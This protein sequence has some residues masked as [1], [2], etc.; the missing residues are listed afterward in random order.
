MTSLA[1]AA[2][3]PQ[4][5]DVADATQLRGQAQAA[6]VA[7]D[8]AGSRRHH[9]QVV[10]HPQASE[11]QRSDSLRQLALQAWRYGRDADA[12]L[13][14]LAHALRIARDAEVSDS[15]RLTR[16]GIA[17]EAGHALQARSDALEVL[18]QARSVASR[19]EAK[20]IFARQALARSR[21]SHAGGPRDPAVAADL[22]QSR[23]FLDEVLEAQPGRTEAAEVQ[24]A[25]GVELGD[26][27]M[28]LRG[29]MG[30]LLFRD[31]AAV[32]PLMQPAHA[33]LRRL[34][35]VWRG[36]PLPRDARAAL[37]SAL[38][39]A[40]F[41]DVAARVAA[42]VSRP[43]NDLRALIA[44]DQFLRDV[45]AVNDSH[46]PR[47]AHGWREHRQAYDAA[48]VQAGS[49]LLRT[50]GVTAAEAKHDVEAQKT[51]LLE[52]LRS[53][54]G[55]EG[56][57]GVTMGF[58]GLLA[59]HVV[60]DERRTIVQHG[61]AGDFRHV[62]IDRLISRDFTSWYGT[63][64]VGGWGTA[65][66]MFQVRA[67]YLPGPLAQLAWVTD[68]QRRSALLERI[69]ALER[70][71]LV[72]C[73]ADP[74]ADPQS[75]PLRLKLQASDRLYRQLTDR[76]LRGPQR[77][78]AFVATL[79]ELS[80]EATVFAHE[81]R[82]ALDQMHFPAAFARMADD[83]RELRAKYSEVLFSRDPRLALT[84]SIL[85]GPSDEL[86]GHGKANRRFRQ[87]LVDWMAANAASVVGLRPDRP[88][89]LQV[90]LLS[91]DQLLRIVGAAD[92]MVPDTPSN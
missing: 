5:G 28:V 3:W 49:R 56:Y 6:W 87:L 69:E 75:L 40:R 63:T 30:Y 34:A 12:A 54:F 53:R 43:G 39:Q 88:L 36:Q 50:L 7:Y 23:R 81:G 68:P 9:L 90:D 11:L 42:T 20:L 52:V 62:S 79:L 41:H 66:T 73:G 29:F 83:E 2:A 21:A 72:R 14:H 92:R 47:V 13:A 10:Q 45:A 33:T 4:T 89:I 32:T 77:A 55:V 26:G 24:L 22:R 1:A 57:F 38:A 19:N 17:L 44:Y 64:N 74:L 37:A 76:G 65:S 18:K 8:L 78:V 15:V 91:A 71:D 58:Y 61:R 59:G 35:G 82:H 46:Y 27:G 60:A 67:A 70:E 25:I 16:A 51:Q 86:T 85:G 80:V 31:E 48:I 84:G